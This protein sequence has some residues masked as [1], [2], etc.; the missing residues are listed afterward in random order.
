MEHYLWFGILIV[1]IVWYAI[2][3]V[4]V[5]LR[6]AKDIRDMIKRLRK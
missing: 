5:A 6:G 2:V 4:L 1:T 3:T